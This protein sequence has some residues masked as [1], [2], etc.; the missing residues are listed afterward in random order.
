MIPILMYHQ[1]DVPPKKGAPFRSLIVHPK[2]FRSQMRWLKRL[3]YTGLSM[4]EIMPYV[5]GEKKGKVIGLTFDDGYR[6]V[7]HNALPVL[8]ELGFSSTNYIV[9]NHIGGTNFWDGE[10]GVAQTPL[11]SADEIVQWLEAGQEIGSHTQDHVH[12]PQLDDEQARHQIEQSKK[13]LEQQFGTQVRSFCY[14]YGHK[15]KEIERWVADSGY[16]NATTT[17]RGLALASDGMFDLPRV[18]IPR[19]TH[20]LHFLQKCLT[21]KEHKKRT[22]PTNL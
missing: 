9:S 3:G 2:R 4:R 17:A 6:N 19:S 18:N 7:F 5:R 20:L 8:I 12:L 11:M 21:Q 13:Q 16:D 1:V 14:P 10:K 15:N 22:T